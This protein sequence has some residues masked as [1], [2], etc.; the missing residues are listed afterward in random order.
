MYPPALPRVPFMKQN[1]AL[2]YMGII[3]QGD[4]DRWGLV[5]DGINVFEHHHRHSRQ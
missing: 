5:E 4:R 1:A 2:M 3:P